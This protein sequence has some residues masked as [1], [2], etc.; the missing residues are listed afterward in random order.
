MLG[1]EGQR[2]A[3][4]GLGQG[5]DSLVLLHGLTTVL[6][7]LPVDRGYPTLNDRDAT[8][9]GKG[10]L[11]MTWRVTLPPGRI[12]GNAITHVKVLGGNEGLVV[13]EEFPT[14][15]AKD[16]GKVLLVYVNEHLR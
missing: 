5:E 10:A 2:R 15:V 9:P 14:A 16:P 3:L 12:L 4:I 11:V 8:N 13:Q 1:P 6:A 7:V